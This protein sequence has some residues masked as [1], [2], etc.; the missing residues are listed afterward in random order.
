[1]RPFLPAAL[2]LC[3]MC[4]CVPPAPAPVPPAWLDHA[5]LPGSLVA[6]G[7]APFGPGVTPGGQEAAA[8]ADG[9]ARLEGKVRIRVQELFTRLNLEATKAAL[10]RRGRVAGPE[11]LRRTVEAAARQV[12]VQVRAQATV[13]ADWVDPASRVR[14]LLV[15]LDRAV[16]ARALAQGARAALTQ[17][18]GQGDPGM[19][20]LVEALE[21]VPVLP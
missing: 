3:A 12:S 13:R 17:G 9:L 8:R 11:A 5:W 1:M 19:D 21:T 6:V 14:Y 7:A 15:G 18:P 10:A 4:A 20:L 2:I 16:L